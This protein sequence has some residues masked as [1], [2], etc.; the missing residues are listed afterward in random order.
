M[1]T[2]SQQQQRRLSPRG[3]LHR[4]TFAPA[5]CD[6]NL[7]RCKVTSMLEDSH[8]FALFLLKHVFDSSRLTVEVKNKVL[9]A[10][11]V[12]PDLFSL[13]GMGAKLS[14]FR[15]ALNF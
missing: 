1:R 10:V 9:T 12:A 14:G 4:L 8:E 5:G 7:E 3:T 6:L 15:R 11:K 13:N 2:E